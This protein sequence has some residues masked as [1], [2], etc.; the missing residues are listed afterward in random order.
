MADI[1]NSHRPTSR[2]PFTIPAKHRGLVAIVVIFLL[3][4]FTVIALSPAPLSYFDVNSLASGGAPL[5]LAADSRC[6]GLRKRWPVR[7]RKFWPVPDG[8]RVERTAE[9]RRRARSP[10]RPSFSLRSQRRT[11]AM[12]LC[13]ATSHIAKN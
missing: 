2:M 11:P 10:R 8:D 5:A 12:A 1:T 4:L 3:A 13:L 7:I 9:A 6:C